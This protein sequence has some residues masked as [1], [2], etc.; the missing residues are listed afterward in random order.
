MAVKFH[1]SWQRNFVGHGHREDQF[2]DTGCITRTTKFGMPF[3]MLH[4]SSS[5]N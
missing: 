2:V 4:G 3:S 1:G 5:L